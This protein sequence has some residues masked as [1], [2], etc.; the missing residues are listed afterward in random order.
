ML[1]IRMLGEEGGKD[2]AGVHEH[3][4]DVFLK[5]IESHLLTQA[6]AVIM[7]CFVPHLPL[8]RHVL[9][10]VWPANMHLRMHTY[11]FVYLSKSAFT[12]CPQRSQSRQKHCVQ[13]LS[14]LSG[15]VY[16]LFNL[17]SYASLLCHCVWHGVKLPGSKCSWG[18][19]EA[20]RHSGDP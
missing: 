20:T 12:C 19:G 10:H 15:D 7:G 5:K 9:M 13:R 2:A 16:N 3:G 8:L 17:C 11:C 6:S 14:Q 18:A 1:Q 4:D